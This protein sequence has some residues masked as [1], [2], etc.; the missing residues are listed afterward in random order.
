MLALI[1]A[2]QKMSALAGITELTAA[3]VVGAGPLRHGLKNPQKDVI[4]VILTVT[5]SGLGSPYLVEKSGSVGA[6]CHVWQAWL[7]HN[8]EVSGGC[9]VRADRA[10]RDTN[11]RMP[12]KLGSS[13]LRNGLSSSAKNLD[14]LVFDRHVAGPSLV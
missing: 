5:P 2:I 7:F 9:G 6:S 10:G 14:F 8:W 3:K 4:S 12:L 11:P 13:P 1:L